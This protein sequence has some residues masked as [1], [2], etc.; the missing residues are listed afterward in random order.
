MSLTLFGNWTGFLLYAIPLIAAIS[1]VYGA[2]RHE[3]PQPILVNAY[4]T[5]KWILG[6]LAVIVGVL[7]VI[8]W[9]T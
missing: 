9:M 4:Q 1:L 2:T 6:F 8:S 7:I 3:L 5:A